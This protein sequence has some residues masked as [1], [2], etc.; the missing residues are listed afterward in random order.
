MREYIIYRMNFRTGVHFGD[1]F[2]NSSAAAC[3]ADTLFSALFLEA[4]K[5]GRGQ[6]L[7]AAAADGR[8]LLSDAMPFYKET[9]FLP[10]P[11]LR[12]RGLDSGN[13]MEK[14]FYKKLR[15]IPAGEIRDFLDGTMEQKDKA[16][17]LW[18][19]VSRSSAAVFKDEDARP[20]QVGICRFAADAGLYVIAAA[21]DPE[22]GCLLDGLFASL[23]RSGIGGRRTE[24]LGRFECC[25]TSPDGSL[26]AGLTGASGIRMLLATSLPRE[27]EMETALEGA[28]FRL[29]QRAGYVFSETYAKEQRKKKTLYMMDAGSCFSNTF[30]G[31]I[32]DV[33]RGGSH[34]VYRY[35]K[36][37]FFAL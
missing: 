30:S 19:V 5:Q 26:L 9:Y 24:G 2:L 34:P 4:M 21:G 36:P 17:D 10:K 25:R 29:V 8:M 23:S 6:A 22:T 12:V 20:Y 32:Y 7:L 13:S 33:S 37:M 3:R 35:G 11:M 28:S 1:G 16:R 14:K 31:D 15:F 18:T 27:D